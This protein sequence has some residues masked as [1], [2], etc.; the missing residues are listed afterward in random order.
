LQL[1]VRR[2]EQ[3]DK[4]IANNRYIAEVNKN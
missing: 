3:K 4:E 1:E 2:L